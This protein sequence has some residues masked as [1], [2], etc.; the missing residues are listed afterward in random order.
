MYAIFLV[1]NKIPGCRTRKN[2]ASKTTVTGYNVRYINEKRFFKF[3]T[4]ADT[5]GSM[6][7]FE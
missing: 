1:I 5:I 7:V 3:L 6:S 2:N 4:T